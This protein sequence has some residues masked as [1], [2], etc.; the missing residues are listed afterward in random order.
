MYRLAT[1]RI[2]RTLFLRTAANS[3]RTT[4]YFVLVA[5][6]AG[7]AGA[8]RPVLSVP[9]FVSRRSRRWRRPWCRGGADG[10]TSGPGGHARIRGLAT[11]SQDSWLRR[12]AAHDQASRDRSRSGQVWLLGE[13]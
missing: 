3:S 13:D 5:T 4:M 10:T 2:A 6:L 7:P 8:E 9:P 1:S 11:R 12:Y